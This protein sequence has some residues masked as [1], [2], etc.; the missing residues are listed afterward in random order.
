ML[1]SIWRTHAHTPTHSSE[2][3]SDLGPG[4]VLVTRSSDVSEQWESGKRV[5][6]AMHLPITSSSSTLNGYACCYCGPKYCHNNNV[7]HVCV[8]GHHAQ[9]F[10]WDQNELKAEDAQSVFKSSSASVDDLEFD[11]HDEAWCL[12]KNG[13][14]GTETKLVKTLKFSCKEQN[15]VL[16]PHHPSLYVAATDFRFT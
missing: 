3:T 13:F 2:I 5:K 12:C 11:M 10:L 9:M 4:Y 14:V 15:V 8:V 1:K 6:V 7:T 16:L